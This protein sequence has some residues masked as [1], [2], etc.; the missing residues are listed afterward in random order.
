MY[1]KFL[2]VIYEN[3]TGFSSLQLIS[4][5]LQNH[6]QGIEIISDCAEFGGVYPSKTNAVCSA[7]RAML[8]TEKTG[9]PLLQ[10]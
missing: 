5:T 6:V 10:D 3:L 1:L 4:L 7:D 2:T 8:R 9:R